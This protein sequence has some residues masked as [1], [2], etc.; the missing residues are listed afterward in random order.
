MRILLKSGSLLGNRYVIRKVLGYGGA[1]TV[2][3]ALDCRINRW[4]AIKELPTEDREV[5][6]MKGLRHP[7]LTEICDV[8]EENGWLYLVMEYIEGETVAQMLEQGKQFSV[9]QVLVYGIQ[10]CQ[11][12]LYLHEQEP[13]V[14]YGDMKPS[15]LMIQP[16]QCLKLIDL[17]TARCVRQEETEISGTRGYAAPERLQGVEDERGDIYSLGVTLYEMAYGKKY[18]EHALDHP[19]THLEEILKNCTRKNPADRYPSVKEVLW[20]L[21]HYE[22]GA[23]KSRKRNLWRQRVAAWLLG[24]AIVLGICGESMQVQAER[25]KNEGYQRYLKAGERSQDLSVREADILQAIDCAPDRPDAYEA[26]LECYEEQGFSAEEYEK[27]LEILGTSG[28]DGVCREELLKKHRESYGRFTCHLG[29]LCFFSWEGYG[30]KSCAKP[31]LCLALENGM[32]EKNQKSMIE[33]LIK[34]AGYYENLDRRITE[35]GETLSYQVFWNDLC[36]MEKLAKG[37]G[38]KELA[39]K[40]IISQ[41]LQYAG[42]FY[43]D[44]VA[45]EEMREKLNAQKGGDREQEKMITQGLALLDLLG[46]GG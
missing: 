25:L 42:E 31:W 35:D 44:G 13:P 1:G 22:E 26:L 11:T 16:D 7:N 37:E 34:I 4:R 3:L 38:E 30:N 46:E 33:I 14:I 32:F 9:V 2:Y 24:G 27:I 45:V 20:E 18:T 10:I 8:L 28:E 6:M 36:E 12:L 21:E 5:G 39:R 17:G 40:E 41:I 15:N 19:D 23:E 43:K 29:M